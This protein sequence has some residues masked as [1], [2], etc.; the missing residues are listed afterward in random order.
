MTLGN[1]DIYEVTLFWGC[2][3]RVSV[4]NMAWVLTPRVPFSGVQT[5]V[6]V[7]SILSAVLTGC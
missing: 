3:V 2:F 7:C 5:V 1:W 4:H 6:M